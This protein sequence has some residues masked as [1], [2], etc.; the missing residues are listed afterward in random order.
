MRD[1]KELRQIRARVENNSESLRHIVD[2]IVSRFSGDMNAEVAKVRALLDRKEALTD[3]EVE[4]LIIRMPVYMYYAASGLEN[5][6]VEMDMSQAVKSEQ[7]NKHFLESA[8]SI[9]D[10]DAAAKALVFNEQMIEVAYSR[11]YKKLKL[12]LEM[13]ESVY[14]GAK[15][16]L[17]KRMIELE[18]S[19]KNT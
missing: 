9:K 16:V 10:R 1:D 15:K 8:G 13:A 7:Y 14:S 17:S 12:Q 11:A 6:G 3:D 2:S 19:Q 18:M 4:K 5:L